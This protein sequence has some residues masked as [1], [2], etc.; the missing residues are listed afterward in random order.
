MQLRKFASLES[1]I[2]FFNNYY[3]MEQTNFEQK[4][5]K[6]YKQLSKEQML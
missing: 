4:L 2:H 3:A 1:N 6:K 5:S